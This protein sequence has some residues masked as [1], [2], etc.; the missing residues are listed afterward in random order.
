M[1]QAASS[2]NSRPILGVSKSQEGDAGKK[3][4]K[5]KNKYSHVIKKQMAQQIKTPTRVPW[6]PP[7][8][9]G[10]RQVPTR[11]PCKKKKKKKLETF[12]WKKNTNGSRNYQP[13]PTFGMVS[14]P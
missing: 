3:K 14:D 11:G 13:L 6:E 9:F 8:N 1:S 4:K 12:P 2:G 5:K 10:G 7:P